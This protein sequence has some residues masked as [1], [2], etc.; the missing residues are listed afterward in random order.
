MNPRE[1]SQQKVDCSP[2]GAALPAYGLTS[3]NDSS[4]NSN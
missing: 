4:K 1:Q 3:L 2:L